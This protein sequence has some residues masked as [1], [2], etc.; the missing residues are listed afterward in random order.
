MFRNFTQIL[1]YLLKRNKLNNLTYSEISIIS[2]KGDTVVGKGRWKKR[3]VG[4]SEVG[5]FLFKLERDGEK[6]PLWLRVTVF[7]S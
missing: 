2:K 6:L 5:K 1:D 7:I 4:K 3:E